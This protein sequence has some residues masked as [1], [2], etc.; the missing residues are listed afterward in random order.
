MI[1]KGIAIVICMVAI[2]AVVGV[3][4]SVY[5]RVPEESILEKEVAPTITYVPCQHCAYCIACIHLKYCANI[6]KYP[7]CEFCAQCK[8]CGRREYCCFCLNGYVKGLDY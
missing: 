7:S 4:I 2:T 5:N 3:T 6:T 1:E 8:L